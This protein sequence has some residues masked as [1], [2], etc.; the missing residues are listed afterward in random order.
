[1]DNEGRA[2]LCWVQAQDTADNF[3]MAYAVSPDGGK[4]FNKTRFIPTTAGVYPHDENLSKILFRKNGDII[5]MFAVSNPNPENDYAGLV[6]YTQ[7]FDGGKTWTA[8]KQIAEDI[9]GSI[10]ERYFDMTL[11]PNGEVAAIWLDSRKE[12]PAEGSSL[13]YA[14]TQG[15]AGFKNEKIIDRQLCQCCRTKLFVDEAGNLH[16]VYRAILNGTVRDMMHLV[17]G[18]NG[19]SFSKPER[20]SADNWA[21]DGCPH[22]GPAMTATGTGLHFVW[23]TMGGGSGVYY[24]RKPNNQGFSQRETVSNLPSARHPQLCTIKNG[25]L[26]IVWDEQAQQAGNLNNRIGLQIRDNNGQITQNTHLSPDSISATHPVIIKVAESAVLVAYTN[27]SAK[28]SQVWYKHIN[29]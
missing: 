16:A 26:V 19:K 27:K 17:S 9:T 4:T 25:E 2:V 1:M 3:L 11:L 23:Y 22:T 15:R 12:M 29:L 6:K 13:Y 14:S 7:S 28:D 18:D 5:A 24:C 21:I 8:A 20:I 10:D